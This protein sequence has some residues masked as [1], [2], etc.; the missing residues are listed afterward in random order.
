MNWNVMIENLPAL[1]GAT[2]VT[3]QLLFLTLLIGGLLAVPLGIGAGAQS[4][5]LRWPIGLYISFFRGTPLLVQIAIV[6]YGLA[7]FPAVRASFLWPILRQAW[8]CALLTLSLHT[9]A[10]TANILRG[11]IANV[12]GGQIEAARACGMTRFQLYRLVILPQ[13]VRTALPSYSNEVISMMKGTSITSTIT[14]ME[15]TGMANT[16]VSRTFAPYE[17][18]IAAALIYLAIAWSLTRLL[19]WVEWRLSAH[20]RSAPPVAVQNKA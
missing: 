9:A 16:I 12:G 14:I 1:L 4:R 18:F 11:A 3:L 2:V 19:R 6:Y 10:Y 7:Q 13:A 20:M 15:L 17:I 5:W 8:P